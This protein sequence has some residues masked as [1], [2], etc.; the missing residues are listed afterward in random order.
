[1]SNAG[2]ASAPFTVP[3][4]QYSLSFFVINGGP[5]VLA[6]HADGSLIGP[7]S[8]FPG[9]STPVVPGETVVLYANGFGPTVPPVVSGSLTQSG[10]LPTLPEVKIA[11]TPCEVAFAGV[12]SPG[13]YQIN[14]KVPPSTSNGDQEIVA[15]YAGQS[16]PA[17]VLITVQAAAGAN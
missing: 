1:V 9:A 14:V 7:A 2:F 8:L 12:I 5:Y 11:G 4:Q 17:H 3:A 15:N 13:L 16:T 10:N 6:Q